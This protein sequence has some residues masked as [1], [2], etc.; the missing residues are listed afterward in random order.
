MLLPISFTQV[1]RKRIRAMNVESYR[2][3]DQNK[4]ISFIL[5]CE[6]FKIKKSPS[7]SEGLGN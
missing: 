3:D 2:F 6:S 1:I 4:C 5:S 7:I